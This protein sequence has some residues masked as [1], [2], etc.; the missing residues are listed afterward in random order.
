MSLALAARAAARALRIQSASSGTAAAVGGGGGVAVVRQQQRRGFAEASG[1]P[2]LERSHVEERVISVV[3]NFEKVDGNKVTSA[4]HFVN[5]LSLDS[6]DTV[7]LVMAFEDEFAI[8]IP[9]AQAEKI[10]SVNDAIE[11]VAGNANAK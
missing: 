9:D 2:Y 4:A 5:D 7:E 3:K 1:G 6:L 8:E 10:L 11:Y